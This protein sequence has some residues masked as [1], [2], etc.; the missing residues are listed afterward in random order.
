M[1]VTQQKFGEKRNKPFHEFFDKTA[2]MPYSRTRPPVFPV[3][4]LEFRIPFHNKNLFSNGFFDHPM[5]LIAF[6]R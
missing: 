6:G 1:S 3:F 5:G 2:V 4:S